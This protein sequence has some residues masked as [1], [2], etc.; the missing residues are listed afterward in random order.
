MAKP[1]TV[2]DFAGDANYP[3]GAEPEAGTPTKTDPARE[4]FGYRPNEHPTAQEF[5]WL[6][7]LIGLWIQWLNALFGTDGSLTL[8]A[9]AELRLSGRGQVT[10]GTRTKFISAYDGMPLV[11]T[12][13]FD[14]S[15]GFINFVSTTSWVVPIDL[16]EG[17]RVLAVRALVR[18]SV[19]GPTTVRM[20]TSGFGAQAAGGN[21]TAVAATDVC[22]FAVTQHYATGDGPIQVV[23]SG[24]LPG[25]LA[26]VTDYWY[27]RIDNDTFKLAKSHAKALRGEAIDITSAGSG[28]HTTT[29]V[30]ATGT[31][32]IKSG[33]TAD[34]SG[35]GTDQV[36]T[37]TGV[38]WIH[39]GNHVAGDAAFS[40]MP[41]A[42]LVRGS[43]TAAISFHGIEVDY[44][45][46][47]DTP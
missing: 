15:S 45:H 31:G 9:D 27:I 37:V 2:V 26:L 3:A 10:H 33:Q 23:T 47:P 34:S 42:R 6:F 32:T 46:P 4:A 39:R 38:G 18:D 28:T 1:N 20:F 13:T 12:D 14:S 25:G 7:N 35:A 17:D 44:D 30:R 36:L 29:D 11:S 16:D 8:D 41:L 19:T 21:F 22:T 5:G 43:G 40:R 24:V